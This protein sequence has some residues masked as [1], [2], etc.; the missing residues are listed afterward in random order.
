MYTCIRQ[1]YA[2]LTELSHKAIIEVFFSAIIIDILK[3]MGSPATK[4]LLSACIQIGSTEI[5]VSRFLYTRFWAETRHETDTRNKK[6]V[7]PTF[8]S[9]P[10]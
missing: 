7:F 4:K 3:K 10:I 8:V 2:T 1:A 6:L 9:A 5:R